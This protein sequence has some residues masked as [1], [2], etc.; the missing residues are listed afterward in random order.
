M[1]SKF[2]IE[3]Y[4]RFAEYEYRRDH[5]GEEGEATLGVF[6]GGEMHTKKIRLGNCTS[7][8][9]ICIRV[10]CPVHGVI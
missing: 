7:T 6:S 2:T 10:T 4:F 8:D 1:A 9:E 3:D 5:I